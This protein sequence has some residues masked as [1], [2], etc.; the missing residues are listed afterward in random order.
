M[1]H[2]ELIWP[3]SH[4]HYRALTSVP[5][6]PERLPYSFE[7]FSRPSDTFSLRP[8]GK[9]GVSRSPAR[10]VE[11][12]LCW[13]E[14]SLV[15]YV[16]TPGIAHSGKLGAGIIWAT[17]DRHTVAG[18]VWT[19]AV[20]LAVRRADLLW[21]LSEHQR[22]VASQR[23]PG[24]VPIHALRFGINLSFFKQE[25]YGSSQE[26]LI[27]TAGGDRHR[28]MATLLDALTIL[29]KGGFR[30]SAILQTRMP[31]SSPPRNVRFVAS[32][33]PEELK[34][35]YGRAAVVVVPTSY[36]Q[37]VSGMTVALEGQATGRPVVVADT[38]GMREY[39][40][41]GVGL[42]YEPGSSQQLAAALS[43]VLADR[44]AAETMG[45]AGRVNVEAR[46]DVVHMHHH[47]R[48]LYD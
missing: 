4:A 43:A 3:A 11:H 36:N 41:D 46:H 30:F 10:Q 39:V 34:Q 6:G 23:L 12:V 15:R 2:F 38:R 7:R 22:D 45:M 19:Q 31:V 37:H 47:L 21:T 18:R 42:L 17:E 26:R 8:S 5:P 29:N 44:G 33:H 32:L 24:T 16:A 25:P 13:D 20:R 40:P 35:L 28:D 1:S 14:S 9:F 48:R 27:V